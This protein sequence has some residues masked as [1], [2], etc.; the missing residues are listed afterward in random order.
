MYQELGDQIKSRDPAL[1]QK[2]RAGEGLRMRVIMEEAPV[3]TLEQSQPGLRGEES[4]SGQ[5]CRMRWLRL[6]QAFLFRGPSAWEHL[7]LILHHWTLCS[8]WVCA[9]LEMPPYLSDTDPFICLI[10]QAMSCTLLCNL[11][12]WWTKRN[13][14]HIV[15]ISSGFLILTAPM[16]PCVGWL[17]LT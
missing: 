17:L 10:F 16:S 13:G 14:L 4:G 8:T 5:P 11:D 15:E 6:S 7:V 1:G 3:V 2:G 9:P 12:T